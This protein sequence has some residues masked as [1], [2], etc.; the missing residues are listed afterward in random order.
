MDGQ[1]RTA[2]VGGLI[3]KCWTGLA[4]SDR[5][6]SMRRVSLCVFLVISL[7]VPAACGGSGGESGDGGGQE[8]SDISEQDVVT[9]LGLV[10]HLRAGGPPLGYDTPDGRCWVEAI[11]IGS[12][13]VDIYKPFGNLASNKDG[14]VGAQVAPNDP[15]IS[16]ADCVEQL[17]AALNDNF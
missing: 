1:P 13:T 10:R 5:I 9:A 12:T 16:E 2:S 8:P 4:D 17:S 6:A 3:N 7:S 14:T 15:S 11:T